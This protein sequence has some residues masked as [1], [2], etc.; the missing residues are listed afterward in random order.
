MIVA[1][2]WI[3]FFLILFT[4]SLAG[5]HAQT[6]RFDSYGIDAAPENANVRIGQ[7]YSDFAFFQSAGIRYMHST[8]A[9]MDYIFNGQSANTAFVPGQPTSYGQVNKDGL[10]FPLVSQLSARNYFLISKYLSLDISFALTFRCYPLGT[11]DN[12]IDIEM[13]DPGFNA[14]M[15]SFTFGATK[16]SWQGSFN[17]RNTQ[18]YTGSDSAG[19]SAN[20]SADFELTPFIRGRVY[21]RPSY[22]VDYVDAH[23]YTDSLSGQRYP[24]FENILGLDL[25]WQMAP[26]KGLAYTVTRDD[27]IP[28]DNEYDIERSVIYHQMLEYRQQIS[29]LTTVGA[30]ADYYWRDYLEQRGAQFQQDYTGF[31]ISDITEYSTVNL[32]LGYSMADISETGTSAYETNGSSDAVIGG[33]GLRTRLTDT[34]SHGFN[35]NR[36]QRAGFIAGYEL[37]DAFRYNI[38]WSEPDFWT[39]GFSTAYETVSPRLANAAPYTD[40]ANQL[41]ASRPLTQRLTLVMAT[42]YILRANDE[43][44]QDGIGD[45]DLFLSNDYNTW[46]TTAGLIQDLTERLKLYYYGEHLERISSNESLAGTRDT[47]GMT[48]GYYYDF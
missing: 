38:L 45:D 15:G 11:E 33:A 29:S 35:Y 19:F 27:V 7:F 18:A 37:V 32:S 34:L 40:W 10:D 25:D 16:D 44:A 21:D 20:I 36:Y 17:G 43:P 46:A 39:L 22:R 1:R 14:Q 12:T 41:T 30:R 8:G 47:I 23:G 6:M 31:L 24:V 28:Q 5:V 26:D 4:M 42:A 3:L 2:R 48:L 13:I 9:G